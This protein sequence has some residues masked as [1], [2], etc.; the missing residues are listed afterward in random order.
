E[1][2]RAIVF[3]EAPHRIKKT[4][5][6]VGRLLVD[7]PM[8]ICRE[9]TKLHEEII[10][11]TSNAAANVPLTVRGEFTIVIGPLQTSPAV[12]PEYIDDKEVF[13]YFYRLTEELA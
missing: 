10:R 8:I 11:T 9:L 1:E 13:N 12:T 6:A 5:A 2:P 3:F 4:L 7:R